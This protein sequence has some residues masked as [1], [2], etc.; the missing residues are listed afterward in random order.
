MIKYSKLLK[1][2]LIFFLANNSFSSDYS[3]VRYSAWEKADVDLLYGLPAEVNTETKVLFIIHGASRD[4]DR[5]LSMWLD[6]A[7]DKNV[8]LTSRM[9]EIEGKLLGINRLGELQIQTK[10]KI[11]SLSDINYSMRLLS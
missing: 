4:A 11:V 6:A 3:V 8:I 5:Y 9:K 7:K 10:E 2:F 1:I